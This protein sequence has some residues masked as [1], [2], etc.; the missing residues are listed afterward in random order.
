MYHGTR[1]GN[2]RSILRSG[3]LAGGPSGCRTDIQLVEHLPDS[4]QRV[5]SGWRSNCELAIQVTPQAASSSGCTF[6][7]SDNEVYLT[8]G[9][10]GAIAPQFISAVVILQSGEVITSPRAGT[11][12]SGEAVAAGLRRA[13]EARGGYTCAVFVALL[14]QWP[15]LT[16]VPYWCAQAAADT[17]VWYP[18][19]PAQARMPTIDLPR[20]TTVDDLHC[21]RVPQALRPT[22]RW[23][24]GW[25]AESLRLASVSTHTLH[26][27]VRAST[28][29]P[30]HFLPGRVASNWKSAVHWWQLRGASRDSFVV[31]K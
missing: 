15:L 16:L 17:L 22:A 31:P 19:L 18:Q 11:A 24:M 6:Y 3:L 9:V 29:H 1:A 20:Y 25:T 5:L 30:C 12:P 8:E 27:A 4:G 28:C 7:Y 14:C 13:R 10:R 26:A 23:P 21:G 2:Y